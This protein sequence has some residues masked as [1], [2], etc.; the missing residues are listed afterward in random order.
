MIGVVPLGVSELGGAEEEDSWE[1]V[2]IPML[3]SAVLGE[4]WIS[5]VAVEVF[6]VACIP[7]E[8]LIKYE[9]ELVT[10]GKSM[11]L[12]LVV[13]SRSET[14]SE[15]AETGEERPLVCDMKDGSEVKLLTCEGSREDGDLTSCSEEGLVW[16]T[17]SDSASLLMVMCVCVESLVP[18][19]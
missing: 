9:G 15:V 2:M 3:L 1:E 11:V 4:G 12:L 16:G 5:T 10:G 14:P 8:V 19:V 6:H 13:C 17:P 7:S 18:T